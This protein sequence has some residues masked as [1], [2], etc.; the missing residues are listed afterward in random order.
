MTFFLVS[1][2]IGTFYRG[3]NVTCYCSISGFHLMVP[4]LTRY[5][6]IQVTI[7]TDQV[8]AMLELLHGVCKGC[9]NCFGPV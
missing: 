3:S 5:E 1:L 9:A 4:F 6:P 8:C 2:E 7:Q